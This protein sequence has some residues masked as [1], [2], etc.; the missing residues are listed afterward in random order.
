MVCLLILQLLATILLKGKPTLWPVTDTIKTT[1]F[2]VGMWWFLSFINYSN[3]KT[4]C[5]VAAMCGYLTADLICCIAWYVFSIRLF[6]FFYVI[7]FSLFILFGLFYAFRSYDSHSDKITDNNVYCLRIK[8]N[9]LQDFLIS[10][11]GIFGSNGGYAICC[12]RK[13]YHFRHGK[14]C[15]DNLNIVDE[16]KYHITKGGVGDDKELQSLLNTKWRLF[17]PNCLTILRSFWGKH[18]R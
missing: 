17:G 13:V 12:N 10:L 8:P 5:F 7:R 4:K 14:L 1:T 15:V 6:L 3:I 9:N 16:S 11:S 18:A 2:L